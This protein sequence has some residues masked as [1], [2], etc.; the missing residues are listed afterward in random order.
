V[1]YGKLIINAGF[2]SL[3]LKLIT[4]LN[5]N[6]VIKF[7]LTL[8]FFTFVVDTILNFS[9]MNFLRLIAD[10]FGDFISTHH[11]ISTIK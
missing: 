11:F 4:I 2:P 3:R 5:F 9:M 8:L 7:I 1:H 6:L 10:N